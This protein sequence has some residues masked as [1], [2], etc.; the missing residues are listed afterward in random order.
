MKIR[1]F[2]DKYAL[3]R[4]AA[5][6]AADFIRRRLGERETVNLIAATGASQFEFLAALATQGGIAWERSAFFHLDEY[7]GLSAKHPASF[8]GYLRERLV[9][10]LGPGRFHEVNGEAPDPRVECERLGQLIRQVQVDMAFIGIGE[11]GH[12]AF[13]DPPADFETEDPYLVVE[14]DEACRRQQLGEGWFPALDAV[15]KQ[16]ISMSVKQILKS[17]RILCIV[18]DLRKAEAVRQCL[19][20]EISPWVPCS[21]LRE[22]EGLELFLDETSASLVKPETLER[23]EAVRS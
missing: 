18:P 4:A 19:E 14:L 9:A 6:A 10:P 7:V 13:N 1:I 3:G 12:I 22:H 17:E 23:W 11:N 16:A 15:P 20:A 5:T 8:R 21:I 2:P